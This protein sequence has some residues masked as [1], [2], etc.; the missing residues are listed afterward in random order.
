VGNEYHFITRWRLKASAEEIF[1]ILSQPVE[2]RRWWPSVYLTVQELAPGEWSGQGRH[3]RLLT[4]GWLPY[5]LRWEARTISARPPERI[6]IEATGDFLGRGIWSIVADGEHCDVTFDWK[7]RAEKTLLRNLSFAFRPAFEANHRWAMEQGRQS[8]E[9]ELRRWR[10]R[11]VEEMN[12]IAAPAG[13][14]RIRK[15][16][17]AAAAI[18]GLGLLS[19]F[20]PHHSPARSTPPA[21]TE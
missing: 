17:L 12:G 5:K 13:P 20:W 2:Y 6:E 3:I 10:A 7:L 1:D 16:S 21:A 19:G 8:I 11:T 4:R 14:P 9:L 18:V 15:R